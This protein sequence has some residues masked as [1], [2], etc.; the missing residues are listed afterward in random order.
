MSS[1]SFGVESG[2]A[3]SEAATSATFVTGVSVLTVAVSVSVASAPFAMLPTVH[4]PVVSSYAPW[5][6]V[7]PT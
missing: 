3:W 2:S 6:G 4:S 5:P 7:A 1:P